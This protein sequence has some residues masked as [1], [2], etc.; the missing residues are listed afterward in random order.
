MSTGRAKAAQELQQL[1]QK[2]ADDLK[3]GVKIVFVG[4]QDIHPPVKVAASFEAVIGA[5]QE[6]QAKLRMAEAYAARAVPM[7]HAE[8]SH[9]VREAEAYRVQTIT[10]ALAQAAQFTNQIVAYNASPEVFLQ[11]SYLQTLSRGSSTNTPKYILGA[12]NTDDVLILN[13]EEKVRREL[14]DMPLPK[15]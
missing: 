7:A 10:G 13:V 3:L 15:K 2:E 8:A 5:G 11:R 12:T 1:L 6:N 14:I 4:L 9:R